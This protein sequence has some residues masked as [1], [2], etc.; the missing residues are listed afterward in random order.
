MNEYVYEYEMK[1]RTEELERAVE[2]RWRWRDALLGIADL[3]AD[4]E[5]RQSRDTGS[6]V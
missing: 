2:R 4:D 6:R 3:I 1:R 5:R